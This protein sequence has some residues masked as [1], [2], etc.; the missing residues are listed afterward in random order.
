MPGAEKIKLSQIKN[1]QEAKDGVSDLLSG[2]LSDR[3]SKKYFVSFKGSSQ[4]LSQEG[5][6]CFTLDDS[7]SA[8]YFVKTTPN[9]KYQGDMY[10]VNIDG[11][12]I[13]EPELYDTG[14]YTGQ[15]RFV[16][17]NDIM[18]FKTDNSNFAFGDMYINKE[19]IDS[20][21]HLS[22]ISVC[23]ENGSVIY[24]TSRDPSRLPGELKIYV[25]GKS[26]KI[27]DDVYQWHVYS[28]GKIIYLSGYDTYKREGILNTWKN[29]ESKKTDEQVTAFIP[30]PNRTIR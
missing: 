5:A 16:S 18:Y 15:M 12:T 7:G 26:E 11:G 24:S 10:R 21:I 20:C 2:L 28:D 25:N 13:S 17:D 9:L 6:C 29:G 19:K 30:V 23:E 1:V 22:S 4:I 8:L 3:S 14:V 27:S